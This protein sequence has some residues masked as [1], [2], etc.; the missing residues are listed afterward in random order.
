MG[1]V[2]KIYA[3]LAERLRSRDAGGCPLV[4]RDSGKGTGADGVR[5]GKGFAVRDDAVAGA[6]NAKDASARTVDERLFRGDT[7][8]N[9][10]EAG[11]V[12]H[13]GFHGGGVHVEE[14]VLQCEAGLHR[15]PP[16]VP[17]SG[18]VKRLR[19]GREV[20]VVSA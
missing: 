8:A 10:W 14:H 7:A 3:S 11:A 17:V 13:D 1:A 18:D 2:V 12:Q 19:D 9:R 15:V 20:R 4:S 5:E 16:V 6:D